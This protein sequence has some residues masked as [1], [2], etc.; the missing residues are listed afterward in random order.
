MCLLFSVVGVVLA[1]HDINIFTQI[2]FV[3][4]V[5]L[6]CKNAI[7]IVE[8]AKS[9]REEGVPAFEATLQACKLRLRPIIMTSFAF[10]LGVVPLMISEGA[11]AEMRRTLGIAVFAGML[12]VTLF[13]I[14]LTPVF[15]YVIQW[16][17]DRR[18]SATEEA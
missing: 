14:F 13:G 2:G 16:F 12:G 9:Q 18:T 1:R 6:A 10:I 5:G 17:A 11:G 3:V 15:Y 7:L 4:L 8:F